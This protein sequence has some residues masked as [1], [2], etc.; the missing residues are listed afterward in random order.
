M[1]RQEM[2]Q[3]SQKYNHAHLEIEYM[4]K[5]ALQFTKQKMDF[6][7]KLCWVKW[8]QFVKKK[9]KFRFMPHT[10]KLQKD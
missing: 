7:N 10:T 2:K 1:K 4:L 6:L 9:K 8:V 5:V 3:K